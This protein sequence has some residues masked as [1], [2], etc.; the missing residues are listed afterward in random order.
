MS[1]RKTHSKEVL[2]T[3][4]SKA[5]PNGTANRRIDSSGREIDR[6]SYGQPNSRFGWNV[7]HINSN[8]KDNSLA[9]LQPLH[10]ATHEEKNRR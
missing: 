5:K 2:D 3:I 1:R 6:A 8:P 4:F 7:D 9:N 10:Y